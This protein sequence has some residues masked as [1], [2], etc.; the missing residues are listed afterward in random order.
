MLYFSYGSNMSTPRLAR[1]IP[2][3]RAVAV[4]SLQEHELRF[5]KVSGKDGSAKCDIVPTGKK[6]DFV[7][8]VVFRIEAAEKPELDRQEGLGNGYEGKRVRVLT[9]DGETLEA[10]TYYATRTRP[11]LKPYGWYKEHVL[12]GAR[13]HGLPVA[14]V[15]AIERVDAVLDPDSARHARELSIY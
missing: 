8:G 14:Y 1:R 15:H 7:H 6:S 10:A 3:A 13:E 9:R 11:G 12:R 2:S 5:H 4:A